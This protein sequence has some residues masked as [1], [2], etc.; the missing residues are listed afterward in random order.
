MAGCVR[1]K[2]ALLR[3]VAS[4]E[5]LDG[6]V[7]AGKIRLGISQRVGSIRNAW[8]HNEWSTV[9]SMQLWEKPNMLLTAQTLSGFGASMLSAALCQAAAVR[10]Q[11]IEM[12]GLGGAPIA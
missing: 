5:F 8:N 4:A 9:H 10:S 12:K 2:K 6:A 11:C 3:H 7:K 1:F